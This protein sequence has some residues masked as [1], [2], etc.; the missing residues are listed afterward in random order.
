MVIRSTNTMHSN[1]RKT[2]TLFSVGIKLFVKI[3]FFIHISKQM[4]STRTC[5]FFKLLTN[6][7]GYMFITIFDIIQSVKIILINKIYETNWWY[8]YSSSVKNT[9]IF[10]LENL[11]KTIYTGWPIKYYLIKTL[12]DTYFVLIT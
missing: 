10:V 5:W 1:K 9:L 8:I 12:N 7:F 6:I 2:D 3:V 4:G 11:I